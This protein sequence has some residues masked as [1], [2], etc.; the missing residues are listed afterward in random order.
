[1]AFSHS[2]KGETYRFDDLK[3]LLAKAIAG[4]V[5]YAGLALLFDVCGARNQGSRMV[6][7]LQAR[8]A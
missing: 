3:T 2:V 5:V 6:R 7:A 8:M 4:A 1:M